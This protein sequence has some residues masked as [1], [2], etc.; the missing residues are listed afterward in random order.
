MARLFL[1]VTTLL[2]MGVGP[3]TALADASEEAGRV[4]YV[5]GDALVIRNAEQV[6]LAEGDRVFSSD[7]LVTGQSGRVSLVMRDDS[8]VFVGRLSRVDVSEYVVKENSLISGGFNM[9]WGKIRFYVARLNKGSEFSVSTQ[10][11]VLGVRGTEFLVTVPI[12]GGITDPAA[13]KLPPGLPAEV[14]RVV[15]IEGVVVGLSRSGER[16][17][18][19]PGVTVEFTQGGE[20][21]FRFADKPDV[22]KSLP[23]A[24]SDIPKIPGPADLRTPPPPVQPPVQPPL[25]ND[26]VY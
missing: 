17:T 26:F 6:S 14:T 13:I 1:F 5:T 18:I 8:K 10:T 25:L 3:N 15:G 19:S 21:I 12:P 20:V 11:A 9:L 23:G 7:T 22:P 16:V 24:G 2:M 4:T